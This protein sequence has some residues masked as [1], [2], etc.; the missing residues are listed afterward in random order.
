MVCIPKDSSYK[1]AALVMFM[2]STI[3]RMT[4]G[5]ISAGGI[6][7]IEKKTFYKT[8]NPETV[9]T[10]KLIKLLA[11]NIFFSDRLYLAIDASHPLVRTTH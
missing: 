1:M 8:I 3:D 10:V 5:M 2:Y 11:I 9:R 7:S 6:T 4:S